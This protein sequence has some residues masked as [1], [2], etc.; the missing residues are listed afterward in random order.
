MMLIN[1]RQFGLIDLYKIQSKV[2]ILISEIR[3]LFR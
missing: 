3:K 1:Q 2:V